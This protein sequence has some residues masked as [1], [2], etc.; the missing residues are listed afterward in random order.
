MKFTV[1]LLLANGRYL[2]VGFFGWG[3]LEE[4]TALLAHVIQAYPADGTWKV[5]QVFE[6][7]SFAQNE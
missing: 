3:T 5:I 4:M 1:A 7:V 6:D 2:N